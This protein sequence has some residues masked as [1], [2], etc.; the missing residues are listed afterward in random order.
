MRRPPLPPA[1]TVLD[2]PLSDRGGDEAQ[3]RVLAVA[4]RDLLAA[5]DVAPVLDLFADALLVEV[6]HHGRDVLPGAWVD[7]SVLSLPARTRPVAVDASRIRFPAVV[8]DEGHGSVLAWGETLWPLPLDGSVRVPASCR[9]GVHRVPALRRLVLTA[10]GRGRE[11]AL[12]RWHEEGFDVP[13]HD[14]RL[15][16]HAVWWFDV[17]QVPRHMRYADA[18]RAQ[19]RPV[20][21]FTLTS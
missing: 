9:P 18:A 17:A 7:E 3:V 13:W 16:P 10:L 14:V 15:V 11:V 19:G 2:L 6:T 20:E 5:P 1:G 4:R 12:T 21:R 8:L